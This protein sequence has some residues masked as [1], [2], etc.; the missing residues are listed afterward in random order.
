MLAEVELIFLDGGARLLQQR[1][2]QFFAE[3]LL[4]FGVRARALGKAGIQVGDVGAEGSEHA[5]RQSRTGP[6]KAV[7]DFVL[8]VLLKQWPEGGVESLTEI[9]MEARRLAEQLGILQFD[10]MPALSDSPRFI[11][12]LADWVLKQVAV[13]GPRW[14][15]P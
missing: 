13:R 5:G 8:G 10:V 2:V 7:E 14:V 12:A 4:Q 6:R 15:C 1:Q 9:N 3:S 11:A